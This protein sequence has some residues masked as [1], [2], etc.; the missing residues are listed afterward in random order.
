MFSNF[1]VNSSSFI[2]INFTIQ[3]RDVTNPSSPPAQIIECQLLWVYLRWVPIVE[4]GREGGGETQSITTL[5]TFCSPYA[6]V[7]NN[8]MTLFLYLHILLDKTNNNHTIYKFTIRVLIASQIRLK[9]P[10]C[11]RF[12]CVILL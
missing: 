2:L 5:T 10:T 8:I 9:P 6:V 7:F 1:L 11:I 12:T 4:G 3:K